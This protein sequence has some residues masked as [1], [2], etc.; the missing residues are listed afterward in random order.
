MTNSQSRR[1][2]DCSIGNLQFDLSRDFVPNGASRSILL[3]KLDFLGRIREVYIFIDYNGLEDKL[4]YCK[5]SFA[6]FII[7]CFHLLCLA[8]GLFLA[9]DAKFS[10]VFLSPEYR[11]PFETLGACI[12][13]SAFIL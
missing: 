8:P 13:T 7:V 11:F 9:G 3:K 5:K 6:I 4:H 1:S 10:S 2:R 12:I